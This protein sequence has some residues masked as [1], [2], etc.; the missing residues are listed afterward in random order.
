MFSTYLSPMENWVAIVARH[1]LKSFYSEF[2][3]YLASSQSNPA[4]L[5]KFAQ[6]LCFNTTRPFSDEETNPQAWIDQLCGSNLRWESLGLLFNFWGGCII[7][8]RAQKSI[9]DDQLLSRGWAPLARE[10]FNVCYELCETFSN[11]NSVML[12]LAWLV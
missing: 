6:K 11:G 5:D 9:M 7:S 12:H 1:V 3:P 4:S 10:C 8:T 2:E